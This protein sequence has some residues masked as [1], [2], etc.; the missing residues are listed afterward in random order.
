MKTKLWLPLGVTVGAILTVILGLLFGCSTRP[1][2]YPSQWE[3]E[4]SL[5]T[6]PSSPRQEVGKSGS[7]KTCA[8][9]PDH[10]L[11]TKPETHP[12]KGE[13]D[14]PRITSNSSSSPRQVEKPGCLKT[15]AIIPDNE[16]QEMRG[17]Y[18]STY[19]F[20]L[21]V[22][23]NPFGSPSSPISVNFTASV[24]AGSNPPTVNGTQA[25]L[26]DGVYTYQADITSPSLNVAFNTLNQDQVAYMVGIGKLSQFSGI[27]QAVQVRNNGQTLLANTNLTVMIPQTMMPNVVNGTRSVVGLGTKGS[28]VGLR[29]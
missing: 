18:D 3:G 2:P 6:S 22:I 4:A 15:C 8:T 16:L 29:Y 9:I 13:G 7:L 21:D 28:L 19:V 25:V 11:Q 20:G 24:P 26:Q 10:K 5:A 14:A 17:C 27:I 23:L 12:S 1:N